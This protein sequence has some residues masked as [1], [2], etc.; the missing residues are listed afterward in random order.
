MPDTTQLRRLPWT[1]EGK[2]V[3]TQVG[4]GG[5]VNQVADQ[6]EAMIVR[7]AK[8]MAAQATRQARNPETSEEI[9][10]NSLT[11]L[12]AAVTD[13]ALVAELRGERLSMED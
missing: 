6:M 12:S 5:T 1:Q 10:R 13:L 8:E 7:T 4:T 3:F 9:L 11:L 2:P